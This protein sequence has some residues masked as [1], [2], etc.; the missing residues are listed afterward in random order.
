MRDRITG[1]ANG[2]PVDLFG[3]ELD[4]R[5]I[6]LGIYTPKALRKGT[7]VTV[8]GRSYRLAARVP[9]GLHVV[10]GPDG[11]DLDRPVEGEEA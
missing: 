8:A 7:R 5:L 11:I 3:V 4:E 6:A 2:T 9:A 1:D 10:G